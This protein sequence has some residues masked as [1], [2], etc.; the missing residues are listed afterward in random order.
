MSA[1]AGIYSLDGRPVNPLE[2][3]RMLDC[4]PHRGPDAE[5]V[6]HSGPI[7]IGHRMLWT[8]PESLEERQPL[9]NGDGSLVLTADARV[10]NREELAS[11][12]ESHGFRLRSNTD[13][14]LILRAYERWGDECPAHI[15]GDFA[16][17]IWDARQQRLFCARD[18]FGVK[19]FHF[20]TDGRRFV[21]A[22]EP[23][24]IL[25][26]STIPL[27]PRLRSLGLFLLQC[28]I[29]RDHTFYDG[30]LRLLPSHSL[31]VTA[32]RT[33]LKQYWDIDPAHQ[34]LHRNDAE[35]AEHFRAVFSEAVQCRLRSSGRV[36][37][38]LS[39][40]LDSSA[41]VCMAESLR[42][43]GTGRSSVDTYSVVCEGLPCD[44]RPYIDAVTARYPVRQHSAVFDQ[45]DDLHFSRA[46][47]YFD[48]LY[49][50]TVFMCF[51][52]LRHARERGTP[53]WLW[54]IGANELMASSFHHLT[55][56]LRQRHVRRLIEQ[57]RYDS[58]LYGVPMRILA[59]NYCVKPMVPAALRHVL[60]PAVRRVRRNRLP[61]WICADFANEI[62][63]TDARRNRVWLRKFPTHSQQH[64]YNLLMVGLNVAMDFDQAD[65][66]ASF[67]STEFR[68]PFMDRR[69]VE[70]LLA[71]PEEQRWWMDRPK[72]ILR[73]GLDGTLP[74]AI[75]DR[76]TKSC[77][78]PAVALAL[79]RQSVDMEPLMRNSRLAQMGAIDRAAL[80]RI[81]DEQRSA[82]PDG[83]V[84]EVTRSAS[85]ILTVVKLEVWLKTVEALRKSREGTSGAGGS[86]GE[87]LSGDARRAEEAISLAAVDQVR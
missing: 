21:W 45:I 15:L 6:W 17:A 9:A 20:Y 48:L 82:A 23:R 25:E 57:L 33:D 77:Y 65:R 16:F 7:G 31:T 61:Q 26:D 32:D 85:T 79:K 55:D 73:R 4:V 50:P 72:A 69:L 68:Y 27:R 64:I 19:P 22:S 3:R 30:I 47:E 12:L 46:L 43:R 13:A 84:L 28:P 53:V 75:R 36:A 54:G 86:T 51:P 41:I 10:D 39:G 49:Q 63:L 18:P 38:S 35:Y 1:I 42:R 24:Q 87:E 81:F 14:E 11:D 2:L 60:R 8:T 76:R 67:H 29:E 74:K 78:T 70:F 34:V 83:N 59:W 37:A 44:E 52:L 71:I 40:G 58:T 56:L 62:G 5:G 66:L 80:R